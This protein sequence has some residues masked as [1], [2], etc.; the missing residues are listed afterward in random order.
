[1]GYYWHMADPVTTAIVSSVIGSVVG[2][3]LAPTPVDAPLGLIRT[4]P[5][6]SKTGEM[7][8]PRDGQVEISGRTYLLSPGAVVR[9]ELNMMVMPLMVQAPVKV[10]FMTDPMGAVNRVW[11][12]SAAEAAL[13]TTR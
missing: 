13:P 11:I 8:P 2:G 5:N 7:Q 12:L 3:L 6:E 1:M 9:N 10:R 4:L